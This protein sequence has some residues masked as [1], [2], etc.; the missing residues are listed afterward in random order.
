M[1]RVLVVDDHA[2]FREGVKQILES[3]LDVEVVGEAA[4]G[5][6]LLDGLARGDVDVVVMDISM[7][8][9]GGLEALRQSRHVRPDVPVLI[10]SMYPEQQ[11]AVRVLKAGAAGYLNKEAAPDELVGAIRKVAAGRKYVS[12]GVAE[13][14][15]SQIGPNWNGLPHEGLSDREF[16]VLRMLASGLTVTEIGEELALS[17]KTVSTYRTR[18]LEKMGMSTNAELTRYALEHQLV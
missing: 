4:S 3:T 7:P 14:L 6:E 12:P 1:V 16:Q 15:V 5:R 9:G 17:V 18:L 2:I 13:Q 8:D 10:L 11:Y